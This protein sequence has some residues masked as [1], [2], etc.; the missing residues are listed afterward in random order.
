MFS[1]I[2]A[3]IPI[4]IFY[5]FGQDFIWIYFPIDSDYLVKCV[6]VLKFFF[7]QVWNIWRYF[8]QSIFNRNR[9][10]STFLRNFSLSTF[11][12]IF[13]FFY[14]SGSWNAIRIIWNIIHILNSRIRII[15]C[16][17]MPKPWFILNIFPWSN[18]LWLN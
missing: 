2:F 1:S 15:I 3:T 10:F 13:L 14:F 7:L 4:V 16:I 17:R 18:L 5:I 6:E 9:F 11:L 12:R 8:L